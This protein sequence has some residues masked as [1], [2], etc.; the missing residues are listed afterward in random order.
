MSLQSYRECLITQ[1]DAGTLFNTYTTA[2][3]VINPN[4]LWTMPPNWCRLGRKL[5][6]RVSG[7]I[8]NIVT[9]PGLMNFQ[10]II[11]GVAAFDSGNIQLNASAHTTIPFWADIDLT[12]RAIGNAT[13]ANLI[14]FGAFTGKMFTLTAGQTDDAQGHMTIIAPVGVPAVGTGFN[15]TIANIVDFFVGFTISNAGNGVQIH[16]YGLYADN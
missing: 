1:P 8:S 13:N 15:S 9:T 14:G 16:E 4:A 6:L 11:G 12:I 7:A 10:V 3:T 5:N 2:K